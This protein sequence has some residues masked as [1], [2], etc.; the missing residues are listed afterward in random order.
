MCSGLQGQ[1][2]Q[3]LDR[4]FCQYSFGSHNN[5]SNS[6]STSSL[7]KKERDVISMSVFIVLIEVM[8]EMTHY[9]V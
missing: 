8:W 3:C 5:N 1:D 9:C 7:S 2:N 6:N 4:V